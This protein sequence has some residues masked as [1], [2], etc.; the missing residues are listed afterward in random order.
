M[1]VK[2]NVW[3]EIDGRVAL[4]RWRVAL[5]EAVQETGSI[6]AAAAQMKISYRRAW[7][8]IRECEDRLGVKLLETQVGGSGGGGASLTAAGREYVERF[9]AL[10]TGLDMQLRQR[11]QEL[12]VD[13]P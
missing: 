13:L 6:S 11:F 5:L 8:K 4:S 2:S 12:F 10:S 7:D 1:Q 9:H 3:I